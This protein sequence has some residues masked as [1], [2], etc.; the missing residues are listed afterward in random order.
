MQND[1]TLFN[2]IDEKRVT[3]KIQFSSIIVPFFSLSSG[4][5]EKA[6]S[7]VGAHTLYTFILNLPSGTHAPAARGAP[8]KIDFSWK[9]GTSVW[10]SKRLG[11][12]SG[13]PPFF[14][15]TLRDIEISKRDNFH[16]ARNTVW[17]YSA[18]QQITRASMG[19]KKENRHRIRP[20]RF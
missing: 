8:P 5:D 6:L 15:F 20:N 3:L 16:S 18:F 14:A 7:S 19:D 10:L 9:V 4:K 11:Y 12:L 17:I 1:A 2:Q 13:A